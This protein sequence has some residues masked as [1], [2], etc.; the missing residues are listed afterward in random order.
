MIEVIDADAARLAL[1]AGALACPSCRTGRLGPWGTARRRVVR[2]SGGML[3][4]VH[5]DRGRCRDCLT[6]HVLLPADVLAGRAYGVEVIGAAL[7]AFAQGRGRRSIAAALDVPAS[8]VAGWTRRLTDRATVIRLEAVRR[9][10]ALDQDLV[11]TAV[12]GRRGADALEA[13]GRWAMAAAA[14]L[15][16]TG[17]GPWRLLALITGGRL[18]RPS[19]P[20]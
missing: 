19:F 9:T 11:P 6:T 1:H 15:R 17:I 13:L 4:T 10:V 20:D 18:L 7:L 16:L 5:P 2:C 3:L 8:T 14:R 12:H